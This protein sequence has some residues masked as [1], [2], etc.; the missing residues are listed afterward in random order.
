MFRHV[1]HGFTHAAHGF[2][3]HGG[4]G[5]VSAHAAAIHAAAVVIAHRHAVA[6]AVSVSHAVPI[7][8]AVAHAAA[9]GKTHPAAGAGTAG[10]V[11]GAGSEQ[12]LLHVGDQI[13]ALKVVV[14]KGFAALG[15]AVKVHQF[16]VG[17][18]KQIVVHWFSPFCLKTEQ[19]HRQR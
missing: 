8:V 4:G 12:R 3:G 19:T 1:G 13:A 17:I 16:A 15:L 7:A 2:A 18:F 9:V 6:A 11:H 14:L 5:I 10:L